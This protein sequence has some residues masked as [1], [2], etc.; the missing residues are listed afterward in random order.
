M[1]RDPKGSPRGSQKESKWL[2]KEV[3]KYTLHPRRAPG[4]SSELQRV[5]LGAFWIN[6]LTFCVQIQ[7]VFSLI[8][9]VFL[10]PF[11]VLFV[12][13]FGGYLVLGCDASD[14]SELKLLS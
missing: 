4:G 11:S 10:D 14:P 1:Q 6:F 7:L 3:L 2:P 12:F 5:I 13:I 8:S 9:I